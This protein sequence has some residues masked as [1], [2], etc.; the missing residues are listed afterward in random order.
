MISYWIKVSEDKE[1]KFS[2]IV[3][4]LMLKLHNPNSGIYN[5][6]WLKK[7][8][9]I[10]ESCNFSNLFRDQQQYS[11]KQFLKRS[12]FDALTQSEQEKWLNDVNTNQFC[13]NYRIF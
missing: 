12:I 13:F 9:E 5:F 11:T 2:N 7:I 1:S 3:Y 4:R 8:Y 6:P 10:L